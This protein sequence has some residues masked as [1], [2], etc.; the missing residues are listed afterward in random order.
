VTDS[1]AAFDFVS[2]YKP[3]HVPDSILAESP[4]PIERLRKE[5]K[6]LSDRQWLLRI[7]VL[8]SV[9]GV[10]GMVGGTL[11]HL[12]SLRLL[13]RIH[14]SVLSVERT[15]L[16]NREEMGD[17]SIRYWKKQR[18]RGCTSCKPLPNRSDPGEREINRQ[19][20]L[21]G[22][23]ANSL[24]TSASLGRTGSHVQPILFHVPD[25]LKD[26]TSI[27]RRSRGGGM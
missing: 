7:I 21:D 6:I 16:M 4:L 19:D 25:L 23:S 10:P 20:I 9:A 17:G 26:G 15:R 11:R 22:R 3:Y 1:R 8:E 12:R 2:G 24:D 5:G 13:V 27:R 14:L 18:M